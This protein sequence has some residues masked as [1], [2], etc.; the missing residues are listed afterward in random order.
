MSI[1]VL[2]S[3]QYENSS[4]FI[5]FLSYTESKEDSV[6]TIVETFNPKKNWNFLDVGCGT[7]E[8]TIPIAKLVNE[9]VVVEPSQKMLKELKNHTKELK[10]KIIQENI[11][12][13]DLEKKFDFILVS[14]VLYFIEDWEK[15]F[16]KLISY[17]NKGGY[18]V[19]ILHAKS[20]TFYD[21]LSKFEKKITGKPQ[22]STYLDAR[23]IFEKM[24]LKTKSKI[25]NSKTIIP[26]VE[27][28][29]I[30]CE[31]FFETALDK[32]SKEV[33]KELLDYFKS[34][35]KNGKV[36]LDERYGLLWIRK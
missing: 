34:H 7:E 9:T 35:C 25:I 32:I 17:L 5:K 1:K 36:I 10:I 30:L 3:K 22:V 12:D 2:D 15:L 14:H 20:G 4:A 18:L 16:Q 33:K 26:S 31:F 29:V 6:K 13:I 28:A 24:G 11:E 21:F 27:E 19:I 23:K 8:I